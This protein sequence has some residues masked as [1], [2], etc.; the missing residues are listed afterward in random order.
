MTPTQAPPAAWRE[1]LLAAADKPKPAIVD[2]E[3]ARRLQARWKEFL[4]VVKQQCGANIVAALN[5]VRDVAVTEHE[6]AFAFGNNEFSR[7]LVAKPDVMPRLT[8]LLAGYLG[9]PVT[10]ECQMGEKASVAGKF[11]AP[12][13]LPTNEADPL[14]EFAVADLGAEVVE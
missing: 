1:H 12:V 5:A 6:V 8:E 3:G 9:R 14:V 11:V 4:N 2:A 10:L 7:N 13:E